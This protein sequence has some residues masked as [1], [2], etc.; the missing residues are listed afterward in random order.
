[1][2]ELKDC[3]GE[4]PPNKFYTF[5]SKIEFT[6]TCWLWKASVDKDGYGK[7]RDFTHNIWKAHRAA[8]YYMF[9]Y[10]PAKGRHLD[11][12]CR[13]RNCVNPHH[14]QDVTSRQNTLRGEG[15]ASI[16]AKKTHCPKGHAYEGDNLHTYLMRAHGT[17]ARECVTC[18]RVKG[19]VR[20]AKKRIGG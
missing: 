13:V 18:R 2:F 9:G 5:V 11:H 7:Y 3:K 17:F 12:L 10:L 6:D 20:S 8:Y 4:V 14:L 19:K 15:V 16:N 1:M